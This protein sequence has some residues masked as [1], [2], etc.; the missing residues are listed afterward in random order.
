MEYLNRLKLLWK[1]NKYTLRE[2][3]L[4][5]YLLI[6]CFIYGS[7]ENTLRQQALWEK[8]KKIYYKR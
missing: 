5:S 4:M 6:G 3:A 8:Y 1:L 7:R 2:K